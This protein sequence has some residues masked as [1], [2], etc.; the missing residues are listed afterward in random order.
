MRRGAQRRMKIGPQVD[1]YSGCLCH[2]E[3]VFL[4][5][6]PTEYL[7]L[8]VHPS[9]FATIARGGIFEGVS[10]PA[11]RSACATSADEKSQV[12]MMNAFHRRE[13]NETRILVARINGN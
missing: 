12:R 10:A 2:P 7:S 1:A 13:A 6:S 9:D 11:G 3:R 8:T 4:S 5:V